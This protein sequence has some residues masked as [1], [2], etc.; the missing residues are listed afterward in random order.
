MS[1]MLDES[2]SFGE[3]AWISYCCVD[4]ELENSHLSLFSESEENSSTHHNSSGNLGDYPVTITRNIILKRNPVHLQGRWEMTI[5]KK[6]QWKI[7]SNKNKKKELTI[8]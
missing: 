5:V 4:T 7:V 3:N 8:K 1:L 6:K 2:V